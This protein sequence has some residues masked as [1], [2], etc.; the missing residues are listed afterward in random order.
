MEQLSRGSA[1]RRSA[2]L[3]FLVE[4][5]SF[6]DSRTSACAILVDVHIAA[7]SREA[8]VLLEAEVLVIVTT[9]IATTRDAATSAASASASSASPHAL[10]FLAVPSFTTST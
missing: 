9:T 6:H 10:E 7:A 1:G 8:I 3:I 4:A 2:I 5:L